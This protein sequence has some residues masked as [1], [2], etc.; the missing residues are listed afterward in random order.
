MRAKTA[1]SQ[2]AKHSTH[3]GA[4]TVTIVTRLRRSQLQAIFRYAATRVPRTTPY[5]LIRDS[6][7]ERAR[8]DQAA[9]DPRMTLTLRVTPEE[10]RLITKAVAKMQGDVSRFLRESTLSVMAESAIQ[11]PTAGTSASFPSG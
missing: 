5:E 1:P 2:C 7:L 11:R 10:G 8:L 3:P 9:D 4:R 6:A